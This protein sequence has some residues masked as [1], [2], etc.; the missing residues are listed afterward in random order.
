MSIDASAY[1]PGGTGKKIKHCMCRDI[2]GEL[3]KVIRALQ[4]NQRVAGLDRINRLL[5]THASRPCLLALKIRTLMEMDDLQNLEET[6]ATFVK[7]APDNA[8]AH[9]F[10][11]FLETRKNRP[12]EAIDALQAGLSRSSDTIPGELYEAIAVVADLL[13]SSREPRRYWSAR[14]LLIYRAM[15]GGQDEEAMKP[16]LEMT[17]EE[18][19]PLL[20]KRDLQFKE[21]P[22]E[23]DWRGAFQGA[24]Q[25]SLRGIW[26]QALEVFEQLD[27]QHPGEEPILWNI[28][29]AR[30][31]LGYANVAEAWHKYASLESVGF[32]AAVVAEASAQLLEPE[33]HDIQ[34]DVVRLSWDVTD[35]DALQE[36]FLSVKELEN[37]PFDP[38]SVSGDEGPPP[39]A[40]FQLLDQP[41][42]SSA[43]EVSLE[44]L[45]RMLS[46]LFLFGKQT[47]RE[48]RLETTVPK[49]SQCAAL[50]EKL[51]ELAGDLLVEDSRNEETVQTVSRDAAELLRR[52]RFP[53]GIERTQRQRLENAK[54]QQQFLEKWPNL[55]RRELDDRTPREVA[56]DPAYRVRLS[57]VLLALEQMNE[58]RGWPIE[59]DPLREQLGLPV[60]EPIVPADEEVASLE[61]QQ[62][63]RVD[64][65]QL[66]DDQLVRLYSHAVLY[67][68]VRAQRKFGQEV[69]GRESMRDKVDLAAVAGG[70]SQLASHPKEAYHW[71]AQARRLAE[72]AG[73]SPARWYLTELPLRLYEGDAERIQHIM[74]VL[75]TRHMNEPGV[76]ESLYNILLRFGV[77]TPDG[78]L[79][80]RPDEAPPTAPET[81]GPEEPKVWTPDAPQGQAGKTQTSKL[82]VPGMD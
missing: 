2:S 60:P 10:A 69:L 56:S 49:N 43:E 15:I 62:W 82:W 20:L 31:Y 8:L 65:S 16:L 5:A 74:T 75:Q 53:D 13:A 24:V 73:Q 78:Q 41:V 64:A 6:V 17:S 67:H 36:K 34:L 25:Q 52:W 32:E 35:A 26:K 70:L 48:A 22:E 46:I 21:A 57:A 42:P 11:A 9:T 51:F 30:S 27:R 66:T 4:G 81:A 29:T 40:V 68:A 44:N 3:S 38:R 58:I 80:Q 54:M 19:V 37:L 55:P 61:P 71:L 45:P 47:D 63:Q 1:C 79:A 33:V 18:N 12:D 59:V 72:Q 7:A 39:K 76:S 14:N 28:A 50:C 23:A 77:I